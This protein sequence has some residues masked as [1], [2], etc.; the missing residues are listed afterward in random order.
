[1]TFTKEEL[2][3][4][5]ILI[6]RSPLSLDHE[7]LAYRTMNKIV[8][9]HMRMTTAEEVEVKQPSICQITAPEMDI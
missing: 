8:N 1:M 7:S 4:L 9:E 2:T 5:Y 3:F 6:S